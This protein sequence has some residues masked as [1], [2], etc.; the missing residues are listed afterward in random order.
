MRGAVRVGD[1]KCR[2][3]QLSFFI[4]LGNFFLQLASPIIAHFNVS[5]LALLMSLSIS[6]VSI[7]I[8]KLSG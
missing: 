1:V 6:A 7:R 3:R 4:I 2:S 8:R 5:Y